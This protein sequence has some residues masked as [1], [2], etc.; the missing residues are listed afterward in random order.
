MGLNGGSG[1]MSTSPLFPDLP[2]APTSDATTAIPE[3][4]QPTG[5][6]RVMSPDRRSVRMMAS[7]LDSLLP[8]DHNARAVWVY[9]ERMELSSLYDGLRARGSHPGRPAIDPALLLAL[10]LFATLEGVGSARQVDRLCREH[11]A[12]RWLCGGVSVNYHALADFRVAHGGL[13][14]KLLVDGVSTL[15]AGGLV[16]MARVAQDGVRVRASAGAASFKRRK[17]IERMRKLAQEQVRKLRDE[18]ETDPAASSRRQQAAR[19]RAAED[20]EQRLD[21]ALAQ[22][23]EVEQTKRRR[24]RKKRGEG[25]EDDSAPPPTPEQQEEQD[26]KQ[27]P[28]VSVTDPEARVMKM[29]GGGFRP[30]YNIQYAV[31]VD[32]GIVVGVDA[33]NIGSDKA[34]LQPMMEAIEAHLGKLPDQALVDSGFVRLDVIEHLEGRGVEIIAPVQKPRNPTRDPFTPLPGDG[35]GVAAWRQRMGTDEAKAAYVLR[36]ATVEWVNA[37]A[38]NRGLQQFPVRGRHKAKAI[39]LWQALAH[40][41]RRA[42]SIAPHIALGAAA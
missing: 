16:D 36:G 1:V 12:Y 7:D 20:L 17:T 19:R 23:D 10:W 11:I 3:A 13:L 32:T 9:V 5:R 15:M 21:A 25:D 29:A 8:P 30:A 18:V 26:K 27:A 34:Q 28:R 40:N 6:P 24:C 33:T 2:D 4:P 41:L 14:E 39:A 31:D 37:Q 42:L 22:M 38:R 35:E